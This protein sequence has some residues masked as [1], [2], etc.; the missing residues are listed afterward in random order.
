MHIRQHKW[1]FSEL[2]TLL[3][4]KGRSIS[5]VDKNI[6]VDHLL[7]NRYIINRCAIF[8]SK[9]ENIFLHRWILMRNYRGYLWS[10]LW[11]RNIIH[12]WD[13]KIARSYYWAPMAQGAE[14]FDRRHEM[15]RYVSRDGNSRYLCFV[16]VIRAHHKVTH[17][18]SRHGNPNPTMIFSIL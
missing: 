9:R 4:H 3:L 12:L 11:F 6:Q 16:S 2:S 5:L 13:A 14:A 18:R 17:G 7:L 8:S 1:N 10:M 15:W